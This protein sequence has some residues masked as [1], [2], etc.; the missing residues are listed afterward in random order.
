MDLKYKNSDYNRLLVKYVLSEVNNYFEPT[1][2][3]KID[4]NYVNIEHIFPQKPEKNW[5]LTKEQIK[6]YVN[7]LGNLTLVDRVINSKA[8]NKSISEKI[9]LLKESEL[10]ITKIIV[11]QI[12]DSGLIWNKDSI[13]ERQAEIAK[14][15]FDEIWKF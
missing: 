5:G 7:L 13:I 12:V 11:K 10:P 14:L 6:D 1:K 8:G 2:E 3:H 9:K 15:A 4:F